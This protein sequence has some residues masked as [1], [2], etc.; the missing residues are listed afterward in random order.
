MK[1]S[2]PIAAEPH[3][4]LVNRIEVLGDNLSKFADS[5][6]P[7][8]TLSSIFPTQPLAD[9]IHIIV[10]SPC[11]VAPP[12]RQ[13]RLAS[14]FPELPS[15]IVKRSDTVSAIYKKLCAYSFIQV[16]GTPASGKSTLAKLLG[17]HIR[18][19]EPHVC[20]IWIGG[21]KIVDVAACGSWHPYLKERKG[22]IPEAA[23]VLIFDDAQVSYQD[24]ELWDQMFKAI[25]EY[26]NL[27]AIA[28]ASYG[29]PS[30][31]IEILDN[32]P[33]Y[34]ADAARVSLLPTANEDNLPSAGL[35]FTRA[36]FDELVSKQYPES[37]HYF[38]SSFLSAVFGI[39]RGHVG[40]MYSFLT[41]I[42]GSDLYR[43]LKH[44][45]QTFTL[46]LFQNRLSIIWFLR[47]FDSVAGGVFR[48]G[49]LQI[50]T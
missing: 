35:H 4:S 6:G 23:T 48:R 14:R 5:L 39:T 31:L 15:N 7:T 26:H 16:R 11:T 33:I 3:G 24:A 1:N 28:F 10:T 41:I 21:W 34:I 18:A 8:V 32:T 19:Q 29:S 45:G 13:H 27:R 2:N 49:L 25:H 42:L 37:E 38:H 22:W 20:V 46:E 44:S 40:A 30:P 17:H 9:C 47:Q 12:R 36:E 50:T 43:E